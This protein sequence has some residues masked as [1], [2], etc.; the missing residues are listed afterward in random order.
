MPLSVSFREREYEPRAGQDKP[1]A[2]PGRYFVGLDLGQ[3]QD[4]TALAAIHQSGWQVP[5][6]VS[7]KP[8][9]ATR[10]LQRWPL[11]SAYTEIV[12]DLRKV[13]GRIPADYPDVTLCVDATGV[14]RAVVDMI[15]KAALPRVKLV[16]ITITAGNEVNYNEGYW[17]VPKKE[18]VGVMSLLLQDRRFQVVPSLRESKTLMRELGTFKVKVKAGTGNE[19]FE[20][21]RER[22]HDDL[23]FAVALPCWFAERSQRKLSVK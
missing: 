18:L 3:A 22:D 4:Y 5:L 19:T 17:H 1:A 14:G 13:L 11:H 23:V 15:R 16:P 9:Y 12:A 7:V 21:W 6:A 2:P 10:L 8:A 20:S